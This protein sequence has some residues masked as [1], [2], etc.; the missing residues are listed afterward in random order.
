MASPPGPA[1]RRPA[2]SRGIP[3]RSI[4]GRIDSAS[5]S[6]GDGGGSVNAGK[7]HCRG[8]PFCNP[9]L[10]HSG[11]VGS[12][13]WKISFFLPN[14]AIL[15]HSGLPA[16]VTADSEGRR[17]RSGKAPRENDREAAPDLA[18]GRCQLYTLL[19]RPHP[20]Q[21]QQVRDER[22]SSLGQLTL[23][24]DGPLPPG[25]S[26]IGVVF[27]VSLNV[28]GYF[29]LPVFDVA[30]RH[31]GAFAAMPMPETAMNE[32]GRPVLRQHQV[33]LARQI[34]AVQSEPESRS[35]QGAPNEQ[36]SRRVLA[37]D[38]S[39]DAAADFG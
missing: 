35:V 21:S 10:R 31:P 30:G 4:P 29:R 26:Q 36:L 22:I 25:N 23:P 12:L 38:P 5:V 17:I 2:A 1:A 11:F 27:P 20:S 6:L 34:L 13:G 28:P 14:S 33:G 3:Q 9:N 16:P 37:L 32:D 7:D 18:R 15:R 19:R 39:H 24:D 8:I